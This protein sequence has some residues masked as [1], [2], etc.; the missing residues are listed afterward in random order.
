MRSTFW[1][2]ETDR[3]MK[4]KAN[5][6]SPTT[7]TNRNREVDELSPVDHVVTRAKPSYFEAQLFILGRQR[8][9]DQNDHQ[10]HK[11]CDVTRVP[12]PQS[13]VGLVV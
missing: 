8:G 12:D 5:T 10:G 4:F 1:H 11:F 6:P 3:V 13:C 9:S 7:E 2:R